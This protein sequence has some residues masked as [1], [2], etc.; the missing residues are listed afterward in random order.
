MN[1]F[2]YGRIVKG[3]HF[4]DRELECSRIVQTLHHGNNVVLYAPRRYG[5][6]SLVFKVM[7][8]LEKLG[9]TVVYIDM[10]QAYSIESF[11]SLYIR[12]IQKKQGNLQK[13][14]N[15]LANTVK[16]VRPTV[17]FGSDG[18]PEFSIDF[19]EKNISANAINE[20]LELPQKLATD[21][22]EVVVVFDEFQ[23]VTRFKEIRFEELLR[24][25]IQQQRV[26]YL[27]L[28]SK[29][30]LLNDMFNNSKRPF[31]NSALTMQLDSLPVDDTIK[32]LRMR[33]KLSDIEID[34]ECCR[35]IINETGNIPYYIQLLAAEVWQYMVTSLNTVTSDVV[36]TC[37]RK[38][39]EIKRDY[40]IELF[41]RQ[42]VH[43]K[44]LL[45]ALSKEG[46]S[47]FSTDYIHKH[48]L[49][50]ASTVQKSVKVLVE[51]GIVDK[52]E[53]EY[54]ISDPFFRKFVR[55]YA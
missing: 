21:G 20:V 5:K 13:F 54:F 42:S 55:N 6:T 44:K 46:S 30:H 2:S 35:L 48:R 40:Y 31:Y 33:F 9:V 24:S 34:E 1:P 12:S 22:S 19:V 11:V 47:I 43:Q 23:E 3:E 14:I 8:Q 50:V 41:D 49:S 39:V 4:Y 18:S 28:G 16:C 36:E 53:N 37:S 32:Y 15:L 38:I 29:T 51:S 27:F 10:M 7:D 25:K 17:S 52:I 45:I 26:N